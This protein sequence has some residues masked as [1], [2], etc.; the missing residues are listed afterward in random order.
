[1]EGY[2]QGGAGVNGVKG[3]RNKKHNWQVQNRQG[4]VKNRIG[5]GEGKELV[6]MT[7]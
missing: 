1:M 7:H 2:Q 4:E 6:Y 5:N 3:T